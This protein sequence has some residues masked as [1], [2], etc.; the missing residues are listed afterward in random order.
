[1]ATSFKSV[2]AFLADV[3]VVATAACARA[4]PVPTPNIEATVEA[5][6]AEE[7]AVDATTEAR[8]AQEQVVAATTAA[9]EAA[10]WQSI[11]DM[12][13]TTPPKPPAPTLSSS[14]LQGLLREYASDKSNPGWKCMTYLPGIRMFNQPDWI[15]VD[16]FALNP[17]MVLRYTGRTGKW[18]GRL[19][20]DRCKALE[21]W[22][23]DDDPREIKYLGSSIAP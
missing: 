6:L 10:I 19:T 20:G 3:M 8:I 18:I 12:K 4:P 14:L 21:S 22:E 11:I 5:R 7:R 16:G 13:P 2:I 17:D 15:T 23:I 9:V 1:M